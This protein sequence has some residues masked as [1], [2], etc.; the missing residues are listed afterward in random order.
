L[1]IDGHQIWAAIRTIIV[2]VVSVYV[3]FVIILWLLQSRLVYFPQREITMT[4]DK[5]RLSYDEMSFETS[6]GVKLSGWFIPAENS[7]GMVLF[8]HGNAGNISHRL[9]S[10]LVF[11]RLSLDVFIFDY[12]GYGQSEGKPT[13]QGTYLDAEAAW[14]Y[15]VENR[16]A[17]PAG[18]VFFGRS[19]GGAVASWLAKKRTPGALIVESAF[20]SIPDIG[21]EAYPFLPVRLMSRFDYSTVDYIHRVTCPVLIV[22]SRDDELISF[23]HGLKIFEASNEPK[24]L[25][26]ISGSH[27]DGFLIS[28]AKYEDGLNH[29]ISAYI[30]R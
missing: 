11:N 19:L 29:F 17:D 8:C 27:N 30:G 13:E 23:N 16:Q 15:L 6:D 21:A 22:H 24:D 5:I 3:V 7:R 18:I 26:E 14:D 10:I 9:E 2:I 1:S 4:P 28:A 25:L 12:R 20:T